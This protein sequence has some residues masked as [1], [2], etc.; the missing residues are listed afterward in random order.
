M[1]Q[2]E[3]Q[4]N[5][6]ITVIQCT[7]N[8]KMNEICNAFI[9]KAEIK[10]KEIYFTYEGKVVS[11][12]NNNL[13]FIEMANSIDKQRKK[14]NILVLDLNNDN[15]SNKKIIKSKNRLCPECHENIKMKI[16]N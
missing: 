13:T 4:F 11:K 16:E 3:F 12:I 9:S 14:M 15:D 7:K 5:G 1:D 2:V 10:D 6:I 8:Q